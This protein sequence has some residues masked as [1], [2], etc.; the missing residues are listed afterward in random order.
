MK[1]SFESVEDDIKYILF[2]LS[3]KKTKLNL[4]TNYLMVE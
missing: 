3:F 4:K 1:S 2:K